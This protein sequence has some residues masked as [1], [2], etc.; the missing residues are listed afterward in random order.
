MDNLN[1]TQH[2]AIRRFSPFRFWVYGLSGISILAARMP[3]RMPPL[4]H[5]A[6]CRVKQSSASR[7]H[8]AHYPPTKRVQIGFGFFDSHIAPLAQASPSAPAPWNKLTPGGLGLMPWDR[9]PNYRLELLSKENTRTHW[10]PEQK[11][12][13]EFG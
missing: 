12:T 6:L 10:E 1:A 3:P 9:L 5:P 2:F 8:E 13:E 7:G 11:P 4:I